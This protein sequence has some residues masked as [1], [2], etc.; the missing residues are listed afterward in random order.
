MP[1]TEP[2]IDAL[3][4]LVSYIIEKSKNLPVFIH[5]IGAISKGQKGS[6]AR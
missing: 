5:P 3:R 6:G 4:R 1:N 2:V